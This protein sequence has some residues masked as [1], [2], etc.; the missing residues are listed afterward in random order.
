MVV[1]V[2][3]GPLLV[4]DV[5]FDGVDDGAD[6]V[7]DAL[8]VDLVALELGDAVLGRLHFAAQRRDALLALLEEGDAGVVRRVGL[9]V[10]EVV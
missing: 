4:L 10:G 2:A 6:L 1:A 3:H 9:G 7:D 5:P 8:G